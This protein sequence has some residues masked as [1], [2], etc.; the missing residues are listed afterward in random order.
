MLWRFADSIV[1]IGCIIDLFKNWKMILWSNAYSILT[2]TGCTDVWY[3][4]IYSHHGSGTILYPIP[5]R[6]DHCWIGKEWSCSGKS[7]WNLLFL[8]VLL[9][10]SEICHKCHTCSHQ[11][12]ILRKHSKKLLGDSIIGC[13]IKISLLWN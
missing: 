5:D 6:K 9:V 7:L 2:Q 13:V 4:I 12:C 8:V 11:L 10:I 3:Y 1:N